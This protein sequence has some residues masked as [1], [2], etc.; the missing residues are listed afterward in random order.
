[1]K[2]NIPTRYISDDISQ[3]NNCI[4]SAHDDLPLRRIESFNVA[5]AFGEAQQ[6][7]FLPDVNTIIDEIDRTFKTAWDQLANL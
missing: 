6:K 7:P 2:I 4:I 3:N 5:F 1:M